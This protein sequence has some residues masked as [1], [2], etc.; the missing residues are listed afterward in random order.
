MNPNMQNNSMA[1]INDD[2]DGGTSIT[3]IKNH[4][5]NIGYVP[6]QQQQQQQSMPNMQNMQNGQ[7]LQ[8]AQSMQNR[9]DMQ[10]MQ[11]IQRMQNY[12]PLQPQTG[13]FPTPVQKNSGLN[14]PND[15]VHDDVEYFSSTQKKNSPDIRH[16]ASD[17]N[18][19][20]ENY[21][22]S[23]QSEPLSEDMDDDEEENEQDE[24][25]DEDSNK[26]SGVLDFVPS[27]LREPL[28]IIILYVIL[29][30][31]FTKKIIGK[32]ITYASPKPNGNMTFVG[33][34]IYGVILA[35]L[36]VLL[37]KLLLD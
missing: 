20:L 34:L 7:S 19:S 32:Y 25:Y 29:S 33:T 4:L 1:F 16:L 18:K 8:Y 15:T 6:Q 27:K 12:N 26:S 31:N 28:L 13:Q 11:N 5:N 17:I 14:M 9:A 37:S 10:N 3:A 30:Q 23:N 35:V 24:D 2:P 21:S 36:Y 22:P